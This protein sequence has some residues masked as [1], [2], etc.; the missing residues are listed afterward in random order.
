[1]NRFCWILTL[2]FALAT[3]TLAYVFLIRGQ[4]LPGGDGRVAIVLEAGER[5]LVLTEMRGFLIAVQGIIDAV[6]R[7]DAAAVAT[8]A[9]QVGAAAQQGVPA[10]LVGKLPMEFKKLGFDT[11][12]KFDQL[13]LDAEQFGEAAAALPALAELMHNCVGC[14]AAYR[15]DEETLA[16]NAE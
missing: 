12:R 2:V 8:A 9:R 14:H 11:H 7:A 1:V 3:G 4:T 15:I 10:T 16:G 13:A 6:V 5:D